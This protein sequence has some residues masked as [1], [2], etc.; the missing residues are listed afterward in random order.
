MAKP[1]ETRNKIT[2]KHQGQPYNSMILNTVA[3]QAMTSKQL[4]VKDLRDKFSK[5]QAILR[6]QGNQSLHINMSSSQRFSGISAVLS[7]NAFKKNR[8]AQDEIRKKQVHASN[9]NRQSLMSSTGSL[10]E[11]QRVSN[12]SK[13]I[14]LTEG[15]SVVGSGGP[16]TRKTATKA[17]TTP[18]VRTR[19]VQKK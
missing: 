4:D 16:T 19:K 8:R 17:V 5:Q 7:Q 1:L 10:L 6:K 13:L 9:L 14:D 2:I 15:E 12:S 11:P 18:Q 3:Q